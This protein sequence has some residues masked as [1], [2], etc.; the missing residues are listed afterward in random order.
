M[1]NVRNRA[2]VFA[3][4]ALGLALVACNPSAREI[5]AAPAAEASLASHTAAPEPFRLEPAVIGTAPPPGRYTA[6]QVERG[7]YLA[8]FGGCHDCHTPMVFD[9]EL[10]MPV[11]DRTRHLS[12][13][14]KGALG[15]EGTLGEHDA[16]VIGPTFTSFK[17]PFG[18]V[19]S[20]NLTPD[21]DTGTGSWTEEMFLN[22]FR[23]GRHLGGAGRG[24]LPPMPWPN[25]RSLS[26]QDLISIFAYLRSLPPIENA[27]PSPEVPEEVI[28]ALRDSFDRMLAIES[29]GVETV[30]AAR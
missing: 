24:V 7:R 23:T 20:A 17:L 18:T 12:G 29:P 10:G 21:I 3:L 28:W 27:V 15:P 2:C 5:P 22:I 4:A 1:Q 14:P 6:A 8:E 26:D 30:V 11:Y 16:A 13:H 19:Y 25:I 9:A